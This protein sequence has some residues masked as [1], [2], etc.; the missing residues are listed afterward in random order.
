M[1]SYAP[2]SQ[3][4]EGWISVLYIRLFRPDYSLVDIRYLA[5]AGFSRLA[6]YIKNSGL[7][8]SRCF[9]LEVKRVSLKFPFERSTPMA[10]VSPPQLL[11]TIFDSKNCT[12]ITRNYSSVHLTIA[13][14]RH[15]VFGGEWKRW[16]SEGSTTWELSRHSFTD[17]RQFWRIRERFPSPFFIDWEPYTILSVR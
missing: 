11:L 5:L 14:S 6:S 4:I 12:Q 1:A 9:Q 10:C 17:R 7:P 16:G 13:C 15:S 3:K 2:V 8:A